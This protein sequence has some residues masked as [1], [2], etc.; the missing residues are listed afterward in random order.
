VTPTPHKAIFACYVTPN[1]AIETDAM[2]APLA[3]TGAAH[4]AR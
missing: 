1:F 4:R 2:S 3:L